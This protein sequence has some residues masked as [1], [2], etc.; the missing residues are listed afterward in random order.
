MPQSLHHRDPVSH[1]LLAAEPIQDG[2]DVVCF[3]PRH[4]LSLPTFGL[5]DILSIIQAYTIAG[6][7][8]TAS[9]TSRFSREV[10]HARRGHGLTSAAEQGCDNGLFESAPAQGVILPTL[11]TKELENLRDTSS[12]PPRGCPNKPCLLCE[13][14]TY[15]R[16]ARERIV[17]KHDHFV[18][19]LPWWAYWP[20]EVL[21]RMVG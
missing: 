7:A 14:V 18:V 19:L 17:V 3:H 21:G 9:A 5:D 15:Q 16:T 20:F 11:P 13:Y 10:F 4:I 1:P 6:A 2:C 12:L 8:R